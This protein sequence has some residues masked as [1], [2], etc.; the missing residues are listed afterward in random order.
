MKQLS[1]FLI[2]FLLFASSKAASDFRKGKDYA[3]FFAVQDYQE[4]GDLKNPIRDAEA[5]ARLLKENFDFDDNN[6]EIVRNPSKKQIQNTLNKYLTKRFE[7]DAQLFIFFSGHGEFNELTNEGFFVPTDAKK[8]DLYQD[9]YLA[10]TRLERSINNIPCPHILLA[11]DACYSG[12]FNEDIAMGRLRS[13]ER[14]WRR[15]GANSENLRAMWIE[16]R[17]RQKSRLFL[18]SGG[19]ERTPDG[20]NH[21]PFTLGLLSSLTNTGQLEDG[22]LTF[23]ELKASMKNVQPEP[24]AGVF[25]RA[26]IDGNF[27]FIQS[28]IESPNIDT[29]AYN[30]R[31]RDLEA[32]EQAKSSNTLTAYKKYLNEQSNGN[33]RMEAR[34]AIKDLEEDLDWRLA[35][36]KHTLV[37]YETYK[38]KYPNGKYTREARSAINTLERNAN[39]N[40]LP[41]NNENSDFNL[42]TGELTETL[43]DE[44]LRATGHSRNFQIV[45]NPSTYKVAAAFNGA[46][47]ILNYNPEFARQIY[48]ND[49]P[50]WLELYYLLHEIG[51]HVEGHLAYQIGSDM[52]AEAAADQYAGRAMQRLEVSPSEFQTTI[53]Q[54]KQNYSRSGYSFPTNRENALRQGYGANTK[55]T[56][57]T[58][59]NL[60]YIGNTAIVHSAKT[61]ITIGDKTIIPN[62]NYF[63][64]TDLTPGLQNYYI[65]GYV[66]AN[67]IYG[68]LQTYYL[69]GSGQ[70]NVLAS[71]ASTYYIYFAQN[72]A[73]QYYFYL[74]GA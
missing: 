49:N 67:D 48:T 12:T 52:R 18:T 21:S 4:W 14:D 63:S 31:V 53:N 3:L 50:Q 27:L 61:T 58:A 19:K 39:N 70:I 56:A 29:D 9:S 36:S 69:E 1:L 6:I 64:I 16:E 7:E 32:W 40:R 44:I 38:R 34:A 46:Q 74:A 55:A 47:R 65:S 22:V 72:T 13:G 24:K 41:D 10:H 23:D 62:G 33:F 68:N 11:I 45:S 60:V 17:L 51:H 54:I 15:P 43:V 28:N 30:Q 25:G 5:V 73:G 35:K 59:V 42:V 71:N 57:T 26:S 37:A 66:Y 2:S 20:I 8:N